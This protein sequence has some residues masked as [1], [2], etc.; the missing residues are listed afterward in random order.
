M[1]DAVIVGAGHNALTAAF[2]LARG[3]LK[4]LVL[5][6]RPDVGGGALTTEIHPG[7]HCPTLSHEVLL[8][9]RIEADMNLQH[10]GV[11]FL[12]SAVHVCAPSLKGHALVISDDAAQTASTIAASSAKDAEAY[13]RFREALSRIA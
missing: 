1:H 9:E 3:G 7:F 13:P 5:E 2:Y 6:R 11:E 4:P 10:D 12:S 8:H